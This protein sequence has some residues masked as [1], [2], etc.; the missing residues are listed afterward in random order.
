[1]STY[2]GVD[3]CTD[4][5]LD[6]IA[7]GV[8]GNPSG[9]S[10]GNYNAVIGDAGASDDLGAKTI[11]DIYAL[12]DARLAAGMPSTAIG[13]YQIIRATLKASL[14][15]LSLG[16]DVKFTPELQ[17]HLAVKLM[18]GRGYS[19]WFKDAITDEEFAH[20]LSLEW[21]S[22]PDPGNGGKSHY[23]GVGPNH[24]STSLAVVYA[25]LGKA[26]AARAAPAAPA[27]PAAPTV[28]DTSPAKPSVPAKGAVGTADVLDASVRLMQ[29][30][31]TVAGYYVGPTDGRPSAALAA[32]LDKYG[33]WLGGAK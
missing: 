19:S 27:L 14:A 15:A 5:I 8:P 18:V 31:M 12:M 3:D 24:A 25:M 2:R 7:G 32:A 20:G 6:F 17:D 1:M 28:P 10:D 13:R 33:A 26:R 23:D 22:L 9:E 16:D 30:V 4:I 21:A 29:T 11:T